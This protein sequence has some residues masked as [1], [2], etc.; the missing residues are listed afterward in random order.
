MRGKRVLKINPRHPIIKEL[1]ERVTQSPEDENIKQTA[2]LIYQTALMESGFILNDPKEFA[3]SIYSTIKTTL[4]VNPDA[5]VEEEDETEEEAV[6]ET[7]E[8]VEM[9]A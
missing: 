4:N 5:T 1:C 3:S 7:K 9:V 2:K 6:V 8:D